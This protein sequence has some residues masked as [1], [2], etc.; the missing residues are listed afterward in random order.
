MKIISWDIGQENL[1]YCIMEDGK[2]AEWKKIDFLE[3]LRRKK[4]VCNGLLKNGSK[5]QNNSL[6]FEISTNDRTYYC[7][8]HKKQAKSEI[9]KYCE[10]EI[11]NGI[12]KNGKKCSM[13]AYYS[14]RENNKYYCKK[15]GD[16]DNLELYLTFKN[17][18]FF[19][20]S[21]LLYEKIMNE[22][23][24]LD[25]DYVIIENQPVHKN[26]IMKSI[27]MLLYSYY[28][29][30]KMESKKIRIKEINLLNA[31]EKMK[32]YDGPEIKC[33]IK[34]LHTKNKFLAIQYCLYF[35]KDDGKWLNY[36]VNQRKQDDLADCF[37]QGLCFLK[38]I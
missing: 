23:D 28:L 35:L 13:K 29:I 38:K 1:A 25:V 32:L 12:N 6:F 5:C 22:P 3:C 19:Q 10:H 31:T 14:D 21:K 17:V 20:K 8:T 2:I 30:K 7:S 36:F 33:D 26:P 4:H 16:S 11:C 24:I 27:Q 15:H 18:S 37:L 34:D 9:F